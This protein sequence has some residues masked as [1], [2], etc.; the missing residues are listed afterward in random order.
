MKVQELETYKEQYRKSQDEV[1]SL[2]AKV[3]VHC[4]SSA[5]CFHDSDSG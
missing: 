3:H 5:Y 4:C 2:K 1:K